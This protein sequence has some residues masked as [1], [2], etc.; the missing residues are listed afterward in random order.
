[1]VW[2]RRS[3][4]AS[5]GPQQLAR[6]KKKGTD[7]APPPPP[8][9]DRQLHEVVA[10]GRAFSPAGAHHLCAVADLTRR[11]SRCAKADVF[12]L[13]VLP[14]HVASV[15]RLRRLHRDPFDRLL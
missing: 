11:S 9:R 14:A 3:T 5:P 12:M 2:A 7:R 8:V 4:I 1:M 6:P 13:P 15:E 10:C